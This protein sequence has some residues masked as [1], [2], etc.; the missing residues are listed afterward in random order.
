MFIVTKPEGKRFEFVESEEGLYFMDTL[1][2]GKQGAVFVNT[3]ADNK[4]K[5]TNEDYLNAVKARELQIK[6]GRPSTKDLI[7]I[8]TSNQLLN[9][10]V[11][12]AD[13]IAAEHIFGPDVGSLKGKTTWRPPHKVRQTVEPL[14]SNIMKRYQFVTL[15]VDIMFVNEIPMLVTMSRGIRFATIEAIPNRTSATLVKGIKSVV[16]L[17][18]RAGFQVTAALMDGEFEKTRNDLNDLGIALNVTGRE[19][20]V[21]DIERF[22]RTVKERM[23][24]IYNTLPFTSIPPR[25]IIEMAKSCVYWLNSFP[26]ARG[27]SD[28]LSPSQLITGRKVDYHRHCKFM[29]G[30]YVQTH[31]QHDNSMAPRTVGAIATRPTGNAQGNFYFFSISTGRMINRTYATPLPM[32]ADVI[33]R[34]HTLAMQQKA[35]PGLL[36]AD[37][38]NIVVNDDDE[39]YGHDSINDE[40]KESVDSEVDHDGDDEYNYNVEDQESVDDEVDQLSVNEEIKQEI[41]GVDEIINDEIAGV[42][43][44]NDVVDIENNDE[45]ADNPDVLNENVVNELQEEVDVNENVE[46]HQRIAE[47]NVGDQEDNVEQEMIGDQEGNVEQEME[48][49]YGPRSGH[50]DLRQRKPR[51]YSHLFT[52][53]DE[54]MTTPQMS[55]KQGIRM[56][57]KSGVDAV[58]K[59]MQQV[60]DR[61]VMLAKKA[62]DLTDKQRE[63]ALAYLMFL[64]RKRCGKIK[65]RGC[66]DGRKQ[67]MYTAK[68]DAASP[69]V[70]IESIFLTAVVDG[71]ENREV[72]VLDV[73]GA[74]MQADM[75]EL[76]HVR[77]TGKMVDL[78]IEIDH[79]M[80]FPCVTYENGVKVMYVELLKALYG[81]I[82][83]ARLFWE[84]LST[85]LNEWGFATNPYDSCV[86]NKIV[87]GKQLTVA[88]HVDDL[89]VSHV[90]VTVVDEFINQM[91][92]E[93]GKETPI[94]KARGKIHDYLGME[95]D[96]SHQ[97]MV[98]INMCEY[99]KSIIHDLPEEMKGT[100]STPAAN[101]L[102]EVNDNP[103][104]LDK[105][106][107]SMFVHLVM[108]LLYLSQRA[109]P[110]IRTAVAFLCGRLK[111][112]DEDDY[113]KL[114]RVMKYL[115]GTINLPLNLKADGSGII[116][117]WVDAS[118]A[119]HDNMRSHTGGTMS[120]GNGSIYSTSVK[121]RIVTRSSTESEV[122]GVHDVLPQII[123]TNNFLREQGV[124]VNET[125]LYQD[126]MSS[127]L[128]EKNGRSSSSKRTRHMNIRFFFIKD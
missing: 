25:L 90:D 104:Y 41:A 47:D 105:E 97:G 67:R 19:E 56:F 127:I 96:Y 117:W 27:I 84:K 14:P 106:R 58:K 40:E 22:I 51:D 43:D 110:D 7:K 123:W 26:N 61:N 121:Q 88:W 1:L 68:E 66:A 86:A 69:T 122:V 34:V 24:A 31:E 71:M 21:G 80:Y 48:Q 33:D 70:A 98:S 18:K 9:C 36:F 63:D 28:T 49:R 113:K 73:P 55:M 75:D 77:F 13:I 59:E 118:F 62:T 101:H 125:V 17:Y 15:C 11:S 126:N 100:A 4:S 29:F 120:L 108:Q 5:Y 128:L 39:S 23:R 87:N 38:R 65:G 124:V 52:N 82:R 109:Q 37:R 3:V 60:H 78:L 103:T 45:I 42:N 64:K 93:F 95:L 6:L 92:L 114:T 99:L 116:R 2:V 107:K 46:Q 32:P 10:P 12:K 112:P 94:N 50:Y 76:V 54:A 44:V 89:K 115:Q 111:Q 20:H 16:S 72:A 85:K 35:N 91:E 119:V 8:V 81:T 74:F 53:V 83:A 79:A 102:F 57:G 30:Q